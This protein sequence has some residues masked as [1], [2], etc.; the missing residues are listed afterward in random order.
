MLIKSYGKLW[1]RKYIHFGWKG[2]K[3]SLFGGNKK[4]GDIDFREQIGIYTLHDK[5][6]NTV[7]IGQAGKGNATI[8]SRLKQHDQD[9]LWNRWSYVSWYGF[10]AVNKGGYLAQKDHIE[11]QFK[12]DGSNL[13]SEIEG[14]LITV[15]EPKLNK[16]GA[17]WVDVE[18]FFQYIHEDLEEYELHDLMEK[19][20]ILEEKIDKLINQG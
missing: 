8:F 10:R 5:D 15:L 3:G 19:Q 14:L 20:N 2:T 13:L 1:E 11:K 4:M 18:E 16:Q 17:K 6:M 9:H 7:Y 12:I